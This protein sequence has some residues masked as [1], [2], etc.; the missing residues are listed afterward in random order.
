MYPGPLQGLGP[1]NVVFL[2]EARLELHQGRNLDAVLA[3]LA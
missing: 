3:R 1:F 2:I